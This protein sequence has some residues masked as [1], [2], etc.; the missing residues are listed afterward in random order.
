[1]TSAP[2]YS[3]P[4]ILLHWL[5]ALLIIS[6]FVAGVK[7]WGMPL[8]PAKFK[9]IAWHKWLGITILGLLV[10]R[11]LVRLGTNAPA[12]PGHMSVSAQRMAHLG[13]LALY[14]LMLLVPLSGWAMSSAYG[15]PVVYFGVVTVPALLAASPELAPW[16]KTLHQ[17]LN[18]LLAI[19]VIGHVVLAFKHHFIDRDG[20]LNRM[21]FGRSSPAKK[22][23]L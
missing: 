9:L 8:S 22:E 10:L 2:R 18:L 7:I 20:L 21:R 19:C 13:H 16:L 6:A 1:M 11:I 15:I 17:A 3:S 14:L 23:S 4:A 12:L 5:M